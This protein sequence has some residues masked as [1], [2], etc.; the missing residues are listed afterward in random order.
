M[1]E[2]SEEKGRNFKAWGGRSEHNIGFSLF[3]VKVCDNEYNAGWH[4]C[5]FGLVSFS[6]S[7]QCRV[8]A[9]VESRDGEKYR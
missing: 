1:S 5:H 6:R 9:A 7:S 4:R 8:F 2:S 3:A